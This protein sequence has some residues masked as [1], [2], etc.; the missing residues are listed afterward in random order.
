MSV[1]EV[2]YKA[3]DNLLPLFSG[4]PVI[5]DIGS[6]KGEWSDV[7]MN[8]LDECD[9]HFFE[10]NEM[11]L[12]YTK[13]KYDYHKNI[14][15]NNFAAWGKD[16]T[17]LDF[18]YFTNENNG[19]SSVY[20]NPQWDYLPMQRGKVKSKTIATYCKEKSIN[21][22]DIIKIDVEGAE[23]DVMFGVLELLRESKVRFIQIEYSPHYKVSKRTFYE[24]IGMVNAFGYN[25]YSFDGDYFK[26]ETQEGFIEDFRLE[27][28][29]VTKE[30]LQNSQD[31]NRAFK[32][33]VE[34]FGRVF[35]FA[36]EIGTFEG[37]TAR[38]I[39]DNMLKK[40]G[41]LI[42]VDPLQDEY[43]TEKIDEQAEQMN[44]SLPY[45]KGQY[46]RFLRNTKRRPV[47]L[48]R[49]TSERAYPLLK[50]FR[51]D[52]IFIDGDHR[53]NAV[54][55]DGVEC[56]KICRPQGYLLFDDYTWSEGTKNAIDKFIKTY[57]NKIIIISKGEQ[58]LIQ[59]QKDE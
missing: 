24:V 18:Y 41:R 50:D 58:V 53:P 5:F 35:N 44:K 7:L 42:C 31:W 8:G 33:S 19:L 25:V 39:C 40:D 56:F 20:H 28:F 45:F 36:L 48:Y 10:P 38:Y 9:V 6:N 14:T 54:Y 47:E 46:G 22:V 21:N 2:E 49:M 16:D 30:Q 32:K 15:Y 29:I 4:K 3:V 51:F 11:L 17:E 37:M 1:G 23:V 55:L 34:D 43:L 27:N 57:E 26:L 13:V 12:T 59:K 52:F